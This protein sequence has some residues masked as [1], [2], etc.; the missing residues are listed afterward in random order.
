MASEQLQQVCLARAARTEHKDDGDLA[1]QF[2]RYGKRISHI[3]LRKGRDCKP[4]MQLLKNSIISIHCFFFVLLLRLVRSRTDLT[5]LLA[6]EASQW[7]DIP[8]Q[9]TIPSVIHFG[10]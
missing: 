7:F 3:G 4:V 8:G 6:V 2:T 1:S 5:C 9:L 10:L